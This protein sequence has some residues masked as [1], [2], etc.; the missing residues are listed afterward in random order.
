M[1]GWTWEIEHKMYC[2]LLTW[3]SVWD[4]APY[5]HCSVS[6]VNFVLNRYIIWICQRFVK[7]NK[8]LRFPVHMKTSHQSTKKCKYRSSEKY[9]NTYYQNKQNI[10]PACAYNIYLIKLATPKYM[11]VFVIKLS[12]EKTYFMYGWTWEIENKMYC[13]LLTWMSVWDYLPY[14]H[15][16][17]ANVNFVLW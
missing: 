3:V 9:S 13:L 14:F 7:Q 6:N 12:K 8:V 1:Y 10:N 17:V 16:S 2:L 15:S 11:F 5:F 4:Y